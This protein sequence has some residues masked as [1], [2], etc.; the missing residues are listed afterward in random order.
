MI[1]KYKG[2]KEQI[3]S[4]CK[5]HGL[6]YEEHTC[7]HCGGKYKMD[8]IYEKNKMYYG[9]ES[10]PCETCKK[11]TVRKTF[12]SKNKDLNN[13]VKGLMSHGD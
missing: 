13:T 3:E 10:S 8:V 2:S 11:H 12:V 6:E 1:K 7:E 4:W 9:F 5:K